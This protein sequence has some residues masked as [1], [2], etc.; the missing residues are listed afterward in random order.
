M[1]KWRFNQICWAFF[2]FIL[3]AFLL[4][5]SIWTGDCRYFYS[6]FVIG[7]YAVAGKICWNR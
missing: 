6:A 5:T 7:A 3:P 2:I 4:L 1:T